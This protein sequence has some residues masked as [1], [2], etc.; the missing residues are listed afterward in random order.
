[1]PHFEHDKVLALVLA[2]HSDVIAAQLGV[3][4]YR[5]LMRLAEVQPYPDVTL[6]VAFQKDFTTPPFGTVAN[7][8]VGVPIP[9]WN[10]NQGSIQAARANLRRAMEDGA[11]VQNDLTSRIADAF[12]RYENNR[13]LLQLYKEQIL[14]SQVKA[15]RGGPGPARHRGKDQLLRRGDFAAN[16]GRP[17]QQLPRRPGG[18]V[19]APSWTSPI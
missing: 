19:D 7:V 12:E 1:M 11:R 8:N 17:H 6:H 14:P 13:V 18:P 10:R 2:N 4:R 16:A 3:D 5:T 15:F 9:L